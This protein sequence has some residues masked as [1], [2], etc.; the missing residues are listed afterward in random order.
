[1]R[2]AVG[3][4]VHAV[5]VYSAN[6]E[7]ATAM[8]RRRL[9]SALLLLSA[10]A[11]TATSFPACSPATFPEALPASLDEVD[12]IRD[13]DGLTLTEKRA[14]LA[15]LGLTEIEI[16]AVLSEER[17]ANQFGGDLLSAYQKL[18]DGRYDE[19]TPDEIQVFG[20][21]A[22]DLQGDLEIS[23]SDTE[24][25]AIAGFFDREGIAT[26]EDVQD[27]LADPLNV[28]SL[29]SD[30]PD[31]VLEDLFVNF[32]IGSLLDELP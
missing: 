31:G 27:F 17:L 1:M 2:V 26:S 14:N 9:P 15:D 24:A 32:D 5:Y 25:Q 8:S 12:R 30:I 10:F 22:S 23:L 19:L 20:D 18:S 11:V 4:A 29:S 16:N 7:R 3:A 28:A 13:D 6:W 21:T